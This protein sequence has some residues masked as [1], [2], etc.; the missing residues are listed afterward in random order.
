MLE[1]KWTEQQKERKDNYDAV[2]NGA[3]WAGKENYKNFRS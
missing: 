1:Y 3:V 2:I